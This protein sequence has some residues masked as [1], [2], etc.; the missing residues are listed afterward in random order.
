[1]QVHHATADH[2]TAPFAG[3]LAHRAGLRPG[4]VILK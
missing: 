1:M 4:D 2:R 3:S